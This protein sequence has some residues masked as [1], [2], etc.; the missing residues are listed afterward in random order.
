[1][2]IKTKY[3]IG[4]IVKIIDDEEEIS[5]GTVIGLSMEANQVLCYKV[6]LFSNRVLYIDDSHSQ[7]ANRCEH[8][9]ADGTC[10]FINI[11]NRLNNY[12]YVKLITDVF[13]D[14]LFYDNIVL[15]SPIKGICTCYD[16][17]CPMYSR[18]IQI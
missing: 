13:A 12:D 1:M 14:Q 6:E 3:N 15:T 17:R 18:K 5:F 7:V 2:E 4:D 9:E 10:K 11:C 8:K 16:E